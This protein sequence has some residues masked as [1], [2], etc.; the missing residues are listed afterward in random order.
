M[1]A[2]G[3]V[4][5]SFLRFFFIWEGVSGVRSGDRAGRLR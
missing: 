2:I 3:N 1:E 4:A 5:L